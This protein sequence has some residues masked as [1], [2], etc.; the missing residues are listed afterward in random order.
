M[1]MLT[2]KTDERKGTATFTPEAKQFLACLRKL[3]SD[4]DAITRLIRKRAYPH[5]K[6]TIK[7]ASSP[8]QFFRYTVLG[9]DDIVLILLGILAE[10]YRLEKNQVGRPNFT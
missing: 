4:W 9:R 6:T 1:A 7:Q 10:E 8:L 5:G 3:D 2:Q